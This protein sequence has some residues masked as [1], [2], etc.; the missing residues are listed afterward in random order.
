MRR[1]GAT[2]LRVVGLLLGAALAIA[3]SGG[4]MWLNRRWDART[5]R[6]AAAAAAAA[7]AAGSNVPIAWT[8]PAVSA[9]GLAQRSGVKITQV[10]VTGNG[11][12]VDLRFQVIDP[13]LA[14]ALHEAGTPP[15]VVDEQSGLVVHDLFMGHSHS[16]SFKAGVTYYLVFENPG[17]LVRRGDKV[18]VLLGDAQVEHVRIG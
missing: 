2:R 6:A 17:N 15:A 9:A 5:Q 1:W 8:R 3:G 10:A 13:D 16:D 4:A 18:T 7:Q 14:N 12:L 11:G